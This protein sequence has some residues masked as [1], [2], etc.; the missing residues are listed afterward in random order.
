MH[1]LMLFRGLKTKLNA[2]FSLE[3]GVWQGTN[4]LC[5]KIEPTVKKVTVE[6]AKGKN[7]LLEE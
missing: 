2:K 6:R 3:K 5:K 4:A 7:V 1:R